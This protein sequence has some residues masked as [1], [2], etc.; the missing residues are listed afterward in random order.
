MTRL[1]FALVILL[2]L[3]PHPSQAQTPDPTLW[4]ANNLRHQRHARRG[5]DLPRRSVHDDVSVYWRR[6]GHR[7]GHHPSNHAVPARHGR[8]LR[9][10]RRRRGRLVYRR[11]PHE[12]RGLR[13]RQSRAYRGGRIGRG[14]ESGG[15][16]RRLRARYLDRPRRRR[17]GA[18]T[19]CGGQTRN[20]IAMLDGT[21]GLAT[22]WNPNANNI[23]TAIVVDGSTIYA[24]GLF[25]SIGGSAR[26]GRLRPSTQPR[27][28]RPP[29]IRMPTPPCMLSH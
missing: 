13:P 14:V 18:F 3:S 11:Q 29:G 16:R 2:V 7:P 17:G 1:P 15:Q 25:T 23:V 20:R 26:V 6:L 24:G 9:G 10:R 19:F 5:H 4:M 8:R 27:D 28:S 21:T 22:A 12:R